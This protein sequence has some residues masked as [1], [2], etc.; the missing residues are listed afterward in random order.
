VVAEIDKLSFCSVPLTFERRERGGVT[1]SSSATGF[2]WRHSAGWFLIT[3]WHNVTGLNPEKIEHVGSFTP[4]H[5]TLELKF[6]LPNV[7]EGMKAGTQKVVAPLYGASGPLWLEHPTRHK[8]DCVALA[9]LISEDY[10]LATIPINEVQFDDIY[11]PSVGDDCFILGYPKG[12]RG[13]GNTPIWKRGSIA[14]EPG[15]DFRGDPMVLVDSATRPGMSGSPVI[16]RQVGIHMRG[17]ELSPDTIIGVAQCFLGIY[18][19][20]TDDDELG[21]QIG[22]VWKAPVID[23]IVRLGERGLDPIDVV[24]PVRSS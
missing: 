19:G 2:L 13:A 10:D 4:S 5:V 7:S 16:A 17:A 22:R 21:V 11:R 23:E 18:S 9:I 3:N 24:Y 6:K 14:S 20:R 15:L 1:G 12:L 8:V